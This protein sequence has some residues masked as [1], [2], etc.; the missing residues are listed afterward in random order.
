MSF[1]EWS[2]IVCSVLSIGLA[3]GP[4]MIT[5][6]AKLAVITSR[7]GELSDKI[8]R[9]VHEQRRLW[10]TA[11]RH[12]ARLDTHDVQLAHVAERLRDD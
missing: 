8:D 11:S 10:D 1:A 12:H 2:L 3:I 5:V 9:Q 7:L 6:H 4:W